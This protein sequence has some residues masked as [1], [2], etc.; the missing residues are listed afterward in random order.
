MYGHGFRDGPPEAAK[1]CDPKPESV[2]VAESVDLKRQAIL[3]KLMEFLKNYT[4]PLFWMAETTA[5]A[6]RFNISIS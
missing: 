4:Y 6:T 5:G 3:M 1:G 2:T